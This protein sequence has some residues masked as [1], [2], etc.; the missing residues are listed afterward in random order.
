[1]IT[2]FNT[3]N[4]A[5]QHRD[6]VAMQRPRGDSFQSASFC[7]P[8]ARSYLRLLRAAE[9]AAWEMTG[10]DCVLACYVDRPDRVVAQAA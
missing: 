6:L 9:M 7:T 8:D 5:R 10:G 2:E 4:R 1:M 3:D